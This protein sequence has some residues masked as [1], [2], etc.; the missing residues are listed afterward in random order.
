MFISKFIISVFAFGT[1]RL[2]FL[3]HINSGIILDLPD[4]T[5]RNSNCNSC[6]APK[7]YL[8]LNTYEQIFFHLLKANSTGQKSGVFTALSTTLSLLSL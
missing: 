1:S 8:L 2:L 5:T 7:L 3:I 4:T 6:A